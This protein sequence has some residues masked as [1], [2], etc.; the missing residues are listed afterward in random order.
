MKFGLMCELE[1]N[2]L[3]CDAQT[4]TGMQVLPDHSASLRIIRRSQNQQL[5]MLM[6]AFLGRTER[7]IVALDGQEDVAV[8]ASDNEI[9]KARVF[10]TPDV[11]LQQ[12]LYGD[13]RS[14]AANEDF[15]NQPIC[16]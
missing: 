8:I 4:L 9:A 16:N 3:I 2:Q 10:S 1:A 15:I 5:F 7:L 12:H 6:I 13:S 14:A 11:Q